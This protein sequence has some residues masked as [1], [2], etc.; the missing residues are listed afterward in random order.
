M[1]YGSLNWESGTNLDFVN[2]FAFYLA[3]DVTYVPGTDGKPTQD[4]LYD[5]R[6]N[7]TASIKGTGIE[8]VKIQS[9]TGEGWTEIPTTTET[10][11]NY[12]IFA[13]SLKG[14][15]ATENKIPPFT[16]TPACGAMVWN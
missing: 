16:I 15:P 4:S 5:L 9:F 13:V 14:K 3:T 8:K 6:V 1:G 2:N 11:G 12:A 7:A 10:T